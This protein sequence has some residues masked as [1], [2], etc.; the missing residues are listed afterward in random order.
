MKDK[1]QQWMKQL[2]PIEQKAVK[3][4]AVCAGVF[5]T[6]LLG[7]I[8]TVTVLAAS[9]QSASNPGGSSGSY[10]NSFPL[11]E[12]ELKDTIL[13]KTEDAG[14]E[15]L[16]ETLFIGDSN[17]AALY[18]YGLLPL[19][20]VSAKVG[21]GVS[22]ASTDACCYFENDEKGY[23]MLE[24]IPKMKPRRVIFS[25][26]T[27]DV[28]Y[29][30]TDEFI[31]EYKKVLSEAKTLYPYADIIV[32]AVYPIAQKN[33]YPDISMGTVD[34]YNQAL[35]DM[36]QQEG[37]KFLNTTEILKGEDGYL[38]PEYANADGIHLKS[39]ALKNVLTYVREHAYTGT[40]DKRPDT[41]NIP[42]RR[43]S[44]ETE[45]NSSSV[46]TASYH[47]EI[48]DGKSYGTLS[49]D[50][51]SGETSKQFTISDKQNSFTVTAV[52]NDG[53]EFVKWSDG[54]QSATRTDKN[55]SA[56]LSVTAIFRAKGSISI[57][58]S[59]TEVKS[60]GESV[61]FEAK[62]SSGA[63]NQTISWQLNGKTL[64][65]ATGAKVTLN[66]KPGDQITASV[67][68]VTSPAIVMKL[69]SQLS[70]SPG[71]TKC[72]VGQTVT[73]TASG[74]GIDLD[75]VVW[76]VDGRQQKTGRN[77]S[78]TPSS[79]QT[80][81]ISATV[82]DNVVSVQLTATS[83][84]APNPQPPTQPDSSSN[85]TSTSTTPSQSDSSSIINSGSNTSPSQSTPEASSSEPASSS[86]SEPE[87][88][89]IPTEKPVVTP[90][91]TPT[92]E[93]QPTP[94][95]PPLTPEE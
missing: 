58:A 7:T 66:V 60:T 86:P 14:Q 13:P 28:S 77:F 9:K 92:Q 19:N 1:I 79:A 56:S 41:D 55:I 71:S 4:S 73:Y 68:G 42:D 63:S 3:V 85:N 70:I 23:T 94:E 80:Y 12:E 44:P 53:Y 40:E 45:S 67:G 83:A 75:N 54:L 29:R 38:K 35:A 46:A 72:Q 64:S 74:E 50:G 16:N 76:K 52:P 36:C 62:L 32:N 30:T 51:F 65:D 17:T 49:G 37:Y 5:V 33:N 88:E 47:V 15:Y 95:P 82:G 26:G 84:P 18:Q 25:F 90:A 43:K 89:P 6:V 93:P 8:I 59:K 87:P 78:F 69:K 57:T 91:P 48:V 39:E 2:L 61:S 22:S 24:T 81:T 11:N 27:N 20:Q 34:A 31:T 21:A 10:V